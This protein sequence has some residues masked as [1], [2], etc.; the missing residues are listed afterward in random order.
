MP[1]GNG[2]DVVIVGAVCTEL[3][4]RLNSLVEERLLPPVTRT[5]KPDVPDAPGV[6]LIVPPPLRLRPDGRLPDASDHVYGV[7]PPLAVSV[8]L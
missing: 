6:P 2:L 7:A 8:A 1:D 4:V 5:V 3:I